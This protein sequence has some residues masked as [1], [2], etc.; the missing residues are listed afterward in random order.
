MDLP[1][2]ETGK[3]QKKQL[4]EKDIELTVSLLQEIQPHQIFIAGDQVDPNGTY[5]ICL[6]ILM[7]S[8]KRVEN[9]SWVKDCWLWLY[10][11][12]KHEWQISEIDMA[13]PLS[14][15]EM[16]RK[17]HAIIK[18]QSQKDLPVFANVNPKESWQ[19]AEDKN[20]QTAELYDQ[21]G[22]SEYEGIE[23]FRRCE[24]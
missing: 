23:A 11:G 19:R 10:R 15:E 5:K 12:T 8:L 1:F 24:F 13:V 2:Y 14:P 6:D 9:E 7:E 16:V 17:R 21:L 3:K 18:H 4:S 20:R 22:L